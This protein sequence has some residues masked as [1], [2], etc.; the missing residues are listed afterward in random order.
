MLMGEDKFG[1]NSV[2]INRA[3]RFQDCLNTCKM[4]DIGFFEPRFTWS[5]HCPFSQLVQESIDRVFV[6][7][8]WNASFPEAV[9]HHLGNTHSDHCPVK[10]CFE[11]FGGIRFPRPFRFQPMWLSHPNF[12][13]VVR[14][15]WSNP[16]S[17]QQAVSN[18][19]SKASS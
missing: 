14:D 3:L 11:K 16:S 8:E 1:G 6:N 2:N 15:A 10:L 17:L 9:V 19:A 4:I 5:N 12:P 18:F 7:A 13:D